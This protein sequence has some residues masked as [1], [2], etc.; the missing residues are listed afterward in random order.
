MGIA[1][2]RFHVDL[3]LVLPPLLE[4]HDPVGHSLEYTVVAYHGQLVESFETVE[5]GG[6]PWK[7]PGKR[8]CVE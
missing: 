1:G 8:C 7:A 6:L 4:G 5:P 3:V 2:F